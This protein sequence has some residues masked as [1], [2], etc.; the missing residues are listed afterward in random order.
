MCKGRTTEDRSNFEGLYK[1]AKNIN[2]IWNMVV[3]IAWHF[4]GT[5]IQTRLAVRV[6]PSELTHMKDSCSGYMLTGLITENYITASSH[7][8][9]SHCTKVFSY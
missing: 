4:V 2:I 5:L 3:F 7:C 9:S 8:L 1:N 6:P